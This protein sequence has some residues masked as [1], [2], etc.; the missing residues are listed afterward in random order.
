MQSENFEV[1]VHNR[2]TQSSDP[3][4]NSVFSKLSDGEITL[5]ANYQRDMV[6]PETKQS[7]LIDSIFL[8]MYIP[9]LL[10][11]YREGLFFC[12]DG[13]Q[14]L[15]SVQR[16]M[17]NEIPWK[18]KSG[19]V[20][21]SSVPEKK[22]GVALNEQQRRWF[23]SRSPMRFVTFYGL[24]E[25][26]EMQMFQRI[27]DGMQLKYTEKLLASQNPIVRY[28]VDNLQILYGDEMDSLRSNKRKEHI[29]LFLRV[30]FLC[31][32]GADPNV[33]SAKKIQEFMEIQD[34]EEIKEDVEEVL[35]FH[36]PNVNVYKKKPLWFFVATCIWLKERDEAKTLEILQ[37]MMKSSK[38][39]GKLNKKN[40]S[41]LFADL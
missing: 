33:L 34:L 26:T 22:T 18:R 9:A 30:C 41:Q 27:Q 10:F 40:I 2:Q 24:E 23:N 5:D 12:V 19:N 4:L 25:K 31:K 28:C 32:H 21:Y 36:G 17:S 1:G 20:W 6:W 13:K 7:M 16:F 15:L 35:S 11:S 3:D 38:L 8:E 37:R 39:D 14:R 29:L